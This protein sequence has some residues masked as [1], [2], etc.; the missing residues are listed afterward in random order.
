MAKR[1]VLICG[2]TGF[3]GRNTVERLARRADIEVHALRSSRPE[4]ATPGVIWHRADLRDAGAVS[5]L[6]AGIDVV[7][8]A[9]ATT[10][11]AK[12]IVTRPYIHVT[13]NAVM[14]SL[15]LRAAYD[16]K[17][18]HFLF[19]SCAVMLQSADKPWDETGFDANREIHARYFGI[20]WT[21]V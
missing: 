2:A 7:V 17:V 11:G 14:N 3:I 4:Y 20:G 8:Q 5:R 1:K 13:D 6:L 10:S 15:L 9:A 18:G 19:F 16:H 21:K 12:D